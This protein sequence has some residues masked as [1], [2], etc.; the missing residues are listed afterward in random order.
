MSHVMYKHVAANSFAGAVSWV[1]LEQGDDPD[2]DVCVLFKQGLGVAGAGKSLG[3]YFYRVATDV[4]VLHDRD[5]AE[6]ITGYMM[7]ALQPWN[8]CTFFPR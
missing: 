1:K 3:V 6:A 8:V 7:A 4:K 2:V 5:S